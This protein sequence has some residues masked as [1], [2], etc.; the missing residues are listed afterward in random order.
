MSHNA[1]LLKRFKAVLMHRGDMDA[2]MVLAFVDEL[3]GEL[4]KVQE[5]T[6]QRLCEENPDAEELG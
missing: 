3:E 2:C 1:V 4:T 5:E 6:I